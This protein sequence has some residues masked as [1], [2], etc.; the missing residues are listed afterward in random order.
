MESSA[1][2]ALNLFAWL[3]KAKRENRTIYILKF[4][5]RQFYFQFVNYPFTCSKSFGLI[6]FLSLLFWTS[7]QETT[8]SVFYWPKVLYSQVLSCKASLLVSLVL[9]LGISILES[10]LLCHL[11]FSNFFWTIRSFQRMIND[12]FYML[13]LC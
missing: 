4:E 8:K 11:F 5:L 13:N 10:E 3:T 1:P 9:F 12:P 6:F 7:T 2:F